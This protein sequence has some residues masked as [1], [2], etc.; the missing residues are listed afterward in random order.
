MYLTGFTIHS[1]GLPANPTYNSV[2][3]VGTKGDSVVASMLPWE[4]NVRVINNWTDIMQKDMYIV[5][6]ANTP[7]SNRSIVLLCVAYRHCLH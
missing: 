1:W 4:D 2:V 3:L 6:F 5:Q 7:V